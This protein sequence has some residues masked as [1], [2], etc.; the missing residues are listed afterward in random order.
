MAR[1]PGV[2]VV[3]DHLGGLPIDPEDQ[4]VL[5]D[6]I[7]SLAKYSN[8]FVKVSNL[9]GKSNSGYPFNNTLRSSSADV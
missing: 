3:L 1:F 2:K 5:I 4:A 9:Q 7:V 6:S 8:V